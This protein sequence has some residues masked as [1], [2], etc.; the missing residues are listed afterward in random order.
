[1]SNA[2]PAF[3]A[4]TVLTEEHEMFRASVRGFIEKHITPFH[5]QWEKDGI[6]PRE[7]WRAAGE[8]DEARRAGH[9]GLRR[10]DGAGAGV[11]ARRGRVELHACGLLRALI[12]GERGGE[13]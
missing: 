10:V 4:R 8:A 11:G 7:V 6:V 5:R 9:E 3:P 12:G 13:R 1:M 2:L